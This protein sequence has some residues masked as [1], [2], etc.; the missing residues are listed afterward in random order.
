MLPYSRQSISP[1]DIQVVIEALNSSFLTQGPRVEA[2][3]E[4]LADYTG[5][6]YALALNSA[7]SALYCAYAAAGIKEGDEVI[8]TPISF[9][10]TSNMLLALGA[11][12]IFC[13]VK[14]DGN[15]DESLIPSL[16]TPKTK[17]IV[18]VDYSGN[19]VAFDR[20][21]SIAKTHGL[22]FISDSS[23]AIGAEF[24]GKRVGVWADATVFSFHAIKPITT[25]EGGALVTDDEAIYERA[26]LLRSHGVE[27]KRLWNSDV[28]SWGFNFR[29]SDFAAALGTSQLKR[30]S[31]FIKRR[32]EIALFYDDSFKESPYFTTL[33]RSKEGKSS[34]HLYPIFLKQEFWCPKEE[35]F[36]ALQEHGLGVQVH[37]KPIHTFSLYDTPRDSLFLPKAESFYLSE[38][39]IPCHQEMGLKEAK[40]VVETLSKVF[41][42]ASKRSLCG[43]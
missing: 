28:H 35:I 36:T 3:E 8:T 11:K 32:E 38:I 12:P 39:S 40:E 37:Y 34:H 26:K 1:E 10:A 15:I 2:F 7:T 9:V 25:G 19:P 24:G 13:D 31:S 16:I 41:Q 21:A 43:A 18:S 17:A 30:L 14:E 27:K 29:M 4:A 33:S 20:I 42:E 23:H 22:A 5:A 6:K